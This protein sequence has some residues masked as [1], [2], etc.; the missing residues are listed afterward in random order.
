M[1]EKIPRNL[2]V[3]NCCGLCKCSSPK[4]KYV[5][6]CHY[7]GDEVHAYQVCDDFSQEDNL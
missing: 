6:D 5:R 3:I 2:R 1:V 7:W 4:E